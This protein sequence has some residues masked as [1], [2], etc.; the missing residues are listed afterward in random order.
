[1]L[2]LLSPRSSVQ[3]SLPGFIPRSLAV[4]AHFI[5]IL[6]VFF[7]FIL[8]LVSLP[9]FFS[10]FLSP[11]FEVAPLRSS[12]VLVSSRFVICEVT[13]AVDMSFLYSLLLLSL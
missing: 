4:S 3:A 10:S 13:K 8:S 9:F 2:S 12:R 11:G 1:M 6:L 7:Q 5:F